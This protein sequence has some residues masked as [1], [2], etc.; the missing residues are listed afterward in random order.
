M[1]D[2]LG[3]GVR[4]ECADGRSRGSGAQ[5]RVVHQRPREHVRGC[6]VTHFAFEVSSH[7]EHKLC[8][9][10]K[11]LSA[12]EAEVVGVGVL[13]FGRVVRVT[14]GEVCTAAALV[15]HSGR[16]HGC[17]RDAVPVQ[18]LLVLVV[19]VEQLQLLLVR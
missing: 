17:R 5:S 15:D 14:V 18:D 10:G 6:N 4:V 11:L 1:E 8:F 7:M 16:G 19:V 9:A 13:P 3:A 12:H 2:A